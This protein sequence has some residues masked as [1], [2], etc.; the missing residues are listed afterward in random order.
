M[1]IAGLMITGSAGFIGINMLKFIKEIHDFDFVL[2]I[3]KMGY[4]TK[5][6]ASLF[7]E[8]GITPTSGVHN[9]ECDIN[10]VSKLKSMCDITKDW[11]A[12]DWTILDFASDSHVD[13]SISNPSSLYN[14]N[15]SIPSNLLAW[16]GKDEWKNI[17]HYY[18]ISTDEVY[19]DIPLEE[20]NDK[21]RYFA[22]FHSLNPSNP[23]SASKVAQDMY[24]TAMYKT[25]SI[26]VTIIRM[27]NQFGLHQHPEKMIPASI[28]RA[29][30][31]ETIK[32]YGEGKNCRQWTFVDDTVQAIWNIMRG[33]E[34]Q[35][36]YA[37][38]VIQL[39]DENN[40]IDNNELINKLVISLKR[41]NIEA[42]IEYINDRPGHDLMYA[43]KISDEDKQFFKTPFGE[44][45]D[46]TVDFYVEGF[47][48][49]LFT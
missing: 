34:R 42:K 22:P 31:G 35:V 11:W 49:G 17:N 48:N 2:S 5:Y 24:L 44:A 15:C 7:R 16:M 23:Y 21:R 26:P 6:N 28:L 29:L 46:K 3:D 1:A 27:A 41:Y 32:I 33:M 20:K 8:I 37:P 18:H 47:R 9:M 38:N 10:D 45:L 25:F 39:A 40:L 14:E 30:R 36:F 12:S 19:G 13:N 43:M 4:A